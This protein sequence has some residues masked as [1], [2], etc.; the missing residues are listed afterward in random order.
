MYP[1]THN[2]VQSSA[3]EKVE[4]GY[5]P[6]QKSQLWYFLLLLGE[7]AVSCQHNGFIDPLTA[8]SQAVNSTTSH[9][10]KTPGSAVQ[11]MHNDSAME[12]LCLLLPLLLALKIHTAHS[13]PDFSG[14]CFV[15]ASAIA[16]SGESQNAD[17][18]YFFLNCFQRK[19]LKR[20]TFFSVILLSKQL[21]KL[22]LKDHNQGHCIGSPQNRTR[23]S[24][25]IK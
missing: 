24:Q 6:V 25:S 20:P 10:N 7:V 13:A 9:F 23:Y 14:K 11:N 21:V 2:I 19:L 16:F 18:L 17:H 4:L 8:L 5:H 22:T 12:L 1:S 15:L 3:E